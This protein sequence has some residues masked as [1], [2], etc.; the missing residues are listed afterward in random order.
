VVA[1]AALLV[2]ALGADQL[3]F[4]PRQREMRQ[5]LAARTQAEQKVLASGRAALEAREFVAYAQDKEESDV[6]WLEHYREQDAF[7]TLEHHR[8]MSGLDRRDVSL[9][10][11]ETSGGFIHTQYFM[12]LR[13]SYEQIMKFF[14]STEQA[15]PLIEVSSFVIENIENSSD[16]SFRL[17]AVVH[18]LVPAA[19]EQP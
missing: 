8:R 3:W 7:G 13:G 17:H 19:G 9:Q 5:L 4:R 2:V 1:A 10:K 11:R 16:L 18:T 12:S 6:D 15:L 14:Q